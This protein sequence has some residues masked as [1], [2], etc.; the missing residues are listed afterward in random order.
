MNSSAPKC[1][2]HIVVGISGGVDSAVT[3]LQ[4]A[5]QGHHLQG[6]FMQNWQAAPDDPHCTA[7]QDLS[8]ARAI[9]DQIGIPLQVVDF[10]K[11]YWDLV[12]QRCL[13]DFAAGFTPNPDILC[14]SEIKF[15]CFLQHAIDNGADYIATGHYAQCKLIN[16]SYEL[17]RGVDNSKDQ[18]YFL[19]ALNQQQLSKAIFPL[20]EI[21]KKQVREIALKANLANAK[22]ADST[23]I[24]FIGERRFKPFLAEYLLAK[25]G[26]IEDEHGKAI[27]K[28]DGLMFY[29]LGQRKGLQIGGCKGYAELP[30]YVI[31]KRQQDNILVVGQ[32][33]QHPKLLSTSL[34]TQNMHWIKGKAATDKWPLK[35]KA[36]IRY[37]QKAA[38][39][40]ISPITNN[41]ADGCYLVEFT[42]PQWAITPGQSVVI[43][44]EDACLG[45]AI[46]NHTV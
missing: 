13:D 17:H 20:G 8:D 5:K 23:G 37:R 6:I 39:C 14:N 7:S 28:H 36:Q 24:C 46:I 38:E 30:W 15:N 19:H 18:S 2:Q 12:F 26:V 1:K 11:Q 29:T 35:C 34:I 33:H 22:K 25:P 44:L 43:Y 3:A 16:D 4:L 31:E 42:E 45:G 9:C 40:N 41:N 27:G 10:S 21:E 32:G